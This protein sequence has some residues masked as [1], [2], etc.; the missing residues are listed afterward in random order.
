MI[1]ETPGG[2]QAAQR[3][4]TT[5][6]AAVALLVLV[7]D[8]ASKYWVLHGLDL[9]ARGTMRLLPVLTLN[10][11]WN[12]GIT[13]GLLRAGVPWEPAVLV[14]VAVLIVGLLALWVRRA[15]NLIVAAALG[16]VA[17][18]ALGNII[19]RIRLGA[20]VDFI[21]LHAGSWDVFP[22]V[23]NL[24]DA[25]IVCGVGTLMLEALLPRRRVSSEVARDTGLQ[26]RD[27]RR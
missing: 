1:R 14:A 8:Q 27:I 26:A 12:Q 6:G 25:A 17:G 9:P 16:A 5:V 7:A 11:V 23:F 20:V 18:G 13:F 22:Y 24:G 15:E 19:D 2:G 21:H 4:R 3:R 10:M